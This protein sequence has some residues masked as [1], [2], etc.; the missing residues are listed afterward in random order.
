MKSFIAA[1]I[2]L[3]SAAFQLPAQEP[4]LRLSLDEAQQ[5]AVERNRT[6]ENASIDVKIAQANRWQAI[7]SMLPQVNASG[8]YNDMFGYRMDFGGMSIALPSS[9]SMGVTASVALS[10]AQVLNVAI[11]KISQQMSDITAQ[12]TEQNIASQVKTLYYSALVAEQTLDLLKSNLHDVQRLYDFSQKSVDVGASEQVSADQLMVQV[13]SSKTAIKGAENSLEMLY[14]SLRVLLD[15]D[16]DTRLELTESLDELLD[17]DAGLAMM[18][19]QFNLDNNYNY[20]LL[21]KN[22]ELARQQVSLNRWSLAPTVSLAYQYSA[23][24]NFGEGMDMTPPNTMNVMVSVPIFSSL[25]NTKKIQSAKMSYQKQLNTL[26]ETE[27][28]LQIQYR[29]LCYNLQNAYSRYVDQKQA[30]DVN[31][32]VFDNISRKYE[33]GYSSA[34]EMTNASTTLINSQSTYVQAILEFVNAQIELENL[35]N[36]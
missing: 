35:L 28:N 24:H 15:L 2:L 16:P 22:V 13:A 12:Q 9:A 34:L 33:Q 31:K 21:K 11:S 30:L 5:M 19:E 26:A 29:Q 25:S 36:N 18:N 10:G 14:N 20:Q 1:V 27:N 23:K 32:R 17:V 3:L 6:L 8:T 7:A 4:P